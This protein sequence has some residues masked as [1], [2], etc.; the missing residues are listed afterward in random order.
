MLD[1]YDKGNLK[2][3]QIFSCNKSLAGLVGKCNQIKCVQLASTGQIQLT[4]YNVLCVVHYCT[5]ILNY[6]SFVSMSVEK[7]KVRGIYGH[8][9]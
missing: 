4:I 6:F 9:V 1:K 8:L 7:V 2:I 3:K 5:T